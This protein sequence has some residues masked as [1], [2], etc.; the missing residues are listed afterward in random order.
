LWNSNIWSSIALACFQAN[1]SQLFAQDCFGLPSCWRIMTVHPCI[2]NYIAQRDSI[3]VDIWVT[4][5]VKV[6]QLIED[7]FGLNS[8]WLIITVGPRLLG[9]AF[10]LAQHYFGWPS[11]CDR[12]WG[13]LTHA[14]KLKSWNWQFLGR[15]TSGSPALWN[16]NIQ[17]RI[18]SA[19]FSADG[20]QL[21]AQDCFDSP[22]C[23]Q[24]TTVQPWIKYRVE[25]DS[26]QGVWHPGQPLHE[27]PTFDQGLL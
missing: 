22:S 17:S 4:R 16:A 6:Q 12:S 15:L 19:S 26:I 9:L 10:L 3:Q 5:F 20:S 13:L 21:L 24:I 2:K 23:R 27:T 25:S 11:C 14:L 1:G 7:C 18:A 8:R